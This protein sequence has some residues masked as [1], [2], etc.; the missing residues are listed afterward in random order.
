MDIQKLLKHKGSIEGRFLKKKTDRRA[1]LTRTELEKILELEESSD[2]VR[3]RHLFY[4]QLLQTIIG[5]RR[6]VKKML[7]DGKQTVIYNEDLCKQFC[8]QSTSKH[9]CVIDRKCQ[10]TDSKQKCVN[11]GVY[12]DGTKEYDYAKKDFTVFIDDLFDLLEKDTRRPTLNVKDIQN[13]ANTIFEKSSFTLLDNSFVQI[14]SEA[15]FQFLEEYKKSTT[16]KKPT[17]KSLPPEVE[18]ELRLEIESRK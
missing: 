2:V 6:R 3:E 9:N 7:K 15:A 8:S 17:G 4:F 18:E 11:G 1:I 13:I 16:P 10:T 12:C 14:I 5:I